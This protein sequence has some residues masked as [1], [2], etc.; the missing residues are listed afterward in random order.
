M[1]KFKLNWQG[2]P[3][4]NQR[5][6]AAAHRN[7]DNGMVVVGARHFDLNIRSQIFAICGYPQEDC[8]D[9]EKWKD[10]KSTEAWKRSEQGFID[11]YGDFLTRPE[12]RVVAEE[13]GQVLHP[14][15]GEGMFYSEH[16]Y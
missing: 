8:R 1:E 7:R 11:N 16:L 5:V 14:K 2:E 4:K 15:H 10:M 13:S 3:K 6:V 12:A 9:Q